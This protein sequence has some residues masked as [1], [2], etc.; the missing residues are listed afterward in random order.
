MESNYSNTD[1]TT[2]YNRL[3]H[4]KAFLKERIVDSSVPYRLYNVV[5][6]I[7]RDNVKSKF[8]KEYL[9]SD[10]TGFS[11]NCQD[12]IIQLF[13]KKYDKRFKYHAQ[14][15]YDDS[16]GSST[17]LTAGTYLIRPEKGNHTWFYIA[18]GRDIPESILHFYTKDAIHSDDFYIYIF[19][20]H[21]KKYIREIDE[22]VHNMWTRDTLGI[23]TVDCSN[24]GNRS[25]S[26]E[27]SESLEMHYMAMQPRYLETMFF[28]HGETETVTQHIQNFNALRNFYESHQILYK[29]GIL[30]YGK[31]GVGKTA[32]TRA[33]ATTYNRD[34]LN[35]NIAHLQ[36][37]DLTLLTQAIDSDNIRK[38]IVLLED[39]DTLFLNRD[40]VNTTRDD[41]AIVNKLLQFLDS[42]TS[43]TDVIFIATTNHID[44]LDPALRRAGRFDVQ[45]MVDELLYE[46]AV[47]YCH[48]FGLDDNETENILNDYD[49][50]AIATG[51]REKNPSTEVLYNQSALQ[52]RVL[53][54][55]QN[56][57]RAISIVDSAEEIKKQMESERMVTQRCG[58]E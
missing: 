45:I 31:P 41:Q 2:A 3:Y 47:S 10:T 53:N 14:S 42:N 22:I 9:I 58:V 48:Y 16:N 25:V 51:Y 8:G 39:I 18:V 11:K 5:E 43:P 26:D 27:S 4:Q 46:D 30:L 12:A 36:N 55:L 40:D 24:N 1:V 35:I 37:I 32:F 33:I 20:R 34:I 15:L 7:I 54:Q 28:S 52:I 50:W 29:T 44:R 49:D 17:R 38:Y 6:R 57:D 19:G 21:Y 23:F 56:K 13:I